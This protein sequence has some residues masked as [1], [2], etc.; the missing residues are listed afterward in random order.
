ME[1]R[2]SMYQRRIA[3]WRR[4]ERTSGE[5]S[6]GILLCK[7]PDSALREPLGGHISAGLVAPLVS[8]S[9]G[10]LS[11]AHMKNSPPFLI[12]SS[13]VASFQ[14]RTHQSIQFAQGKSPNR[15][16]FPRNSC[17]DSNPGRF[18]WSMLLK[19]SGR[20]IG[21]ARRTGGEETR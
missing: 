2:L 15:R 1:R 10:H 19:S 9:D 8:W 14:W 21:T 7:F 13:S 6:I 11:A 5:V 4:R 20:M 3:R 16:I 17:L 12:A 18:T